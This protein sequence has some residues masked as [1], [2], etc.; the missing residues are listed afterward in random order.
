M[1]A[2][3]NTANE[4]SANSTNQWGNRE[5]EFNYGFARVS[6]LKLHCVKRTQGGRIVLSDVEIRGQHVMPTKRFWRSFF[7]RF[8]VSENMFRY[9][10]PEEIFLRVSEKN[11][12]DSF[13]YCVADSGSKVELLAATNSNRPVIRYGEICDLV[14][15]YGGQDVTYNEGVVTSIH[16]PRGGAR[17]FAIGGDEFRDRFVMET[18]VD[19]Y[20]H[21]RLFL[22]LLR[23]VCSNGAIGYSRAFRSDVSVGKHMDHCIGR[24]LESFDNG[25]GYAAL[26]QRFESSQS[27]WASVRE[28]LTLGQ[29][30]E[31]LTT[32]HKLKVQGLFGRL[33]RMSGDMSEM[34]G[35]ANL[36]ALSDKRK[37]VLPSRCRV[38]DLINFAS[39]VATHHASADGANRMQA[40]I[41]S[42]ISDEYDLEGTATKA[43]DFEA[44][45]MQPHDN[46]PLLKN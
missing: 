7:A 14:K 12:D 27:S 2:I 8:G 4:T 32:G 11:A 22:S 25:D 42:L 33:R 6:D 15:R 46:P 13:R 16:E 43:T 45:F 19:G 1:V 30:V 28:V 38:Y 9:F 24:A 41:G 5:P 21:P 40:Y 35:L 44:F 18:P 23:L 26:R 29:A 31:K 39:E 10:S 34:Y 17:Q 20:G 36:D 37:R 3:V